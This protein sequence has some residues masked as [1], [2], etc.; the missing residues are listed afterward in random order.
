MTVE[1]VRLGAFR[2]PGA[3]GQIVDAKSLLGLSLTIEGV[4]S[5]G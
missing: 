4:R 3:A 1:E 5:G 2:S